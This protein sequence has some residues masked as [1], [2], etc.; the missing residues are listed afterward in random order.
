MQKDKPE[1]EEKNSKR[2][3]SIGHFSRR[4]YISERQFFRF[5]KWTLFIS[6]AL[7]ELLMLM[8]QIADFTR[9]GDLI[10]FLF[11]LG[12]GTGLLIGL[13]FNLFVSKRRDGRILFSI[14]QICFWD[15]LRKMLL[16][17]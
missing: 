2:L 16:I 13:F 6:L 14:L 17:E 8:Q 15:L 3:F 1:Q 12:C 9:I 4:R 11:V 10:P 5:C 7:V